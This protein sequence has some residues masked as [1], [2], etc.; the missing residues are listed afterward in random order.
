MN[1]I[2]ITISGPP[3][4]GKSLIALTV[5]KALRDARIPVSMEEMD[6]RKDVDDARRRDLERIVRTA[7]AGKVKVQVNI[8]T[9]TKL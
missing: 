1:R 8:Q 2:T 4:S 6:M 3:K 5:E 7:V 9:E